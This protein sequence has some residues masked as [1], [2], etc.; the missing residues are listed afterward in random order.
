MILKKYTVGV[1]CCE[2]WQCI[3]DLLTYNCNE[4]CIPSRP[5]NCIDDCKHSK[6]RSVY[7]LTDD[8]ALMLEKHPKINYVKLSPSYNPSHSRQ[9]IL[10][11]VQNRNHYL[12]LH[13]HRKY[14]LQIFQTLQIK[15]WNSTNQ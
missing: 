7:E 5:C 6:Y 15:N 3:H 4:D 9:H 8:E 2:D 12:Q 13:Y 14:Y 1:K 11:R 10:L